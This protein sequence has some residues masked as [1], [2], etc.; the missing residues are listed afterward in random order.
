MA[1]FNNMHGAFRG[2]V[3]NL[4]GSNWKGTSVLRARPAQV[5]NP[6][7]EKQQTQRLKFKL[8]SR[9]L[10]EVQPF[11]DVGFANQATGKS[12]H[13]AAMSANMVDGFS[14][15]FPDIVVSYPDL[16]LSAGPIR[17]VNDLSLSNSESGIISLEWVNNGGRPRSNN[18]DLSFA[19]VYNP[20]LEEAIF[21]MEGPERA[22]E[23][24]SFTLPDDYMGQELHVWLSFRDAKGSY[25][26]DS[27]YAGSV[28]LS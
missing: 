14:G 12:T 28:T 11:I 21:E 3:G 4:V 7:T 5:R 17:N 26:S 6:N 9:F 27:R 1:R 10:R 25:V 20:A 22:A 8:M 2:R 13:N 19:V 24:L 23:Q 18:N 16:R 15:S